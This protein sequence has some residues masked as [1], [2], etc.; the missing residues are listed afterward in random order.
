MI[1]FGTDPCL[2][3]L[4]SRFGVNHELVYFFSVKCFAQKYLYFCIPRKMMTTLREDKQIDLTG[5]HR[6]HHYLLR[7]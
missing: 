3:P 6:H 4:Q 7:M 1:T 2:L 5:A